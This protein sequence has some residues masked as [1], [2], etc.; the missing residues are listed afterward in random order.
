MHGTPTLEFVYDHAQK[1]R[2]VGGSLLALGCLYGMALVVSWVHINPAN[3]AP[4]PAKHAASSQGISQS[5]PA[6]AGS[7]DTNAVTGGFSQA[8]VA[9][10][11]NFS[12]AQTNLAQASR[13]LAVG[14]VSGSRFIVHSGNM[15][16]RTTAHVTTRGLAAIAAVP[17]DV[18]QAAARLPWTTTVLTAEPKPAGI[19]F[20]EATAKST[21]GKLPVAAP[22]ASPNPVAAAAPAQP[23][24]AAAAATAMPAAQPADPPGI[25]PLHGAVTTQFG[26]PELP[27]QSIHTG[28]DISD[29]KASGVTPVLPF[30]PGTV[31]SVI[32]SGQGLGNHVV[33]DHG[34]GVT[35]VYGHLY[36]TAVQEGQRVDQ[37]TALGLEGS[38]GVSTGTH[39]HFEIRV[40]GVATDPHK[41]IAGQPYL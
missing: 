25:W 16:A 19:A 37:Q 26:V 31:I 6:V 9:V 36:S 30:K 33:V 29:G 34:N 38:T 5:Q 21:T 40:N 27:Y 13:S 17:G 22:A 8:A 2:L 3:P 7:D 24:A 4:A 18:A 39:L 35:S 10:S 11:Q 20:A 1:L 14:A 23:P 15:V 32:N 41:F 28:L 12:D